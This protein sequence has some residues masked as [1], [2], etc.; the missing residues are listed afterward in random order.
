M[1]KPFVTPRVQVVRTSILGE[2]FFFATDQ[3]AD[4]VQRHH[5]KGRL[6]EADEL[7]IM[8][9]V[10]PVGGRFLD[11]GANTG[12]HTLFFGKIMK[13]TDILPIEVN[14]RIIGILRSNICLNGLEEVCDLRHLGLG[15]YSECVDGASISF[16][17]R[18]IGGATITP[19][20]GALSLVRGDDILDRA[21]DLVKIDVEGSELEVLKGMTRFV[22]EYRPKMFIEV[23]NRNAEA[24]FDWAG[25]TGYEVVDEFR[26]Y[27]RN[28]NY[29]IV[30]VAA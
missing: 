10:F 22:A 15:L 20:G 16:R 7:M 4:T 18:N 30:P 8:S 17:E 3:P 12:N 11:I 9:R 23:A 14:P 25:E 19:E 21:F 1:S 27:K 24:F 28:C 5:L 29:L 26:R 2:E 13:A 6:Y